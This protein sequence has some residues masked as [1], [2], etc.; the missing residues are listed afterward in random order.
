[1]RFWRILRERE[2]ELWRRR[3]NLLVEA[4]ISML[5]YIIEFEV[6]ITASKGWYNTILF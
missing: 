3:E 1:M 5:E 2:V 6:E 4:S